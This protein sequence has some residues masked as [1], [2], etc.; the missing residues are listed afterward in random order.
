MD[1]HRKYLVLLECKE[2]FFVKLMLFIHG[3][4]VYLYIW[5]TEVWK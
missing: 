1:Y 4:P 3:E 5:D 2:P